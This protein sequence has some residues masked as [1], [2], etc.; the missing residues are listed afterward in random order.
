[1]IRLEGATGTVLGWRGLEPRC[2]LFYAAVPSC[3]AA[4][5]SLLHVQADYVLAVATVIYSSSVRTNPHQAVTWLALINCVPCDGV[6]AGLGA[7]A[8][9]GLPFGAY[10]HMGDVDP[11]A[12]WPPTPVL[13]PEEYALRASRWISRGA[14]ILGGC[15]G[16]I[17]EHIAALARLSPIRHDPCHPERRISE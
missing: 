1:M 9:S 3:N 17:P 8:A 5:M 4:M 7:A 10:A 15:C 14:S 6:D 11:E 12:G 2:A 13:S 16:T